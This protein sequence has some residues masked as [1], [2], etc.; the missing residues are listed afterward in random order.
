MS[1]SFLI[2]HKVR[3][4]PAFDIAEQMDCPECSSVGQRQVFLACDECDS[5]GYWWILSTCGY[6]AHP[7][8]FTELA[9]AI[10]GTNTMDFLSQCPTPWPDLFAINDR[11][12]KHEPLD[13][14]AKLKLTKAQAPIKRR[15]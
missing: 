12:I 2:A 6:R 8:W 14:L 13:L 4:Q 10:G 1:N 5:L 15:I 11:P 7:Y 3:G 9:W